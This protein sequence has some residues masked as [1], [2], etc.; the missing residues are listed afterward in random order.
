[1]STTRGRPQLLQVDGRGQKHE[2][3]VVVMNAWP[4]L[5]LASYWQFR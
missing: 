3:F 5:Q 1:M 2:F 4:L